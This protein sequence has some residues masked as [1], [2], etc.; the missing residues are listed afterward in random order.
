MSKYPRMR[1]MWYLTMN[2]RNMKRLTI[3]LPIVSCMVA[4]GQEAADLRLAKKW[5]AD[6]IYAADE[7]QKKKKE[8]P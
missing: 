5:Q 7:E 8:K 1:K 2:W 3:M 6:E 4:F